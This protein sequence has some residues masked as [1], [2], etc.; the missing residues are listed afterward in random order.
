MTYYC[1]IDEDERLWGL[2]Y[3]VEFDDENYGDIPTT[4]L[5]TKTTNFESLVYGVEDDDDNDG[6]SEY[7]DP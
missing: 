5:L 4:V 3:V 2:D 7:S 6:D 1:I